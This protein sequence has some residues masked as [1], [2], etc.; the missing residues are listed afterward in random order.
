[1]TLEYAVE[2]SKL[3]ETFNKT[4]KPVKSKQME[5]SIFATLFN[6]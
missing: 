3:I 2:C 4:F 5:L 6:M 1:M